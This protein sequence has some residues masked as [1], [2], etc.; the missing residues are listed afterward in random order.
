MGEMA[1]RAYYRQYGMKTS[2]VRIFTAYGP[3]EK[4]THAI[5]ALIAKAF[6][7]M[8]TYDLRGTGEHS[9][10][11]TYVQDIVDALLVASERIE[12][13]M[14]V[15]AGRDDQITLREA[16]QLVF[17]IMGWEPERIE[18]DLT[19]PQGVSSR[20]ADLTHAK[21][22]LRWEPRVS[23]EEGFRRTIDWYVATKTREGA[24]ADLEKNPIQ[25]SL[26]HR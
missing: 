8:D 23:Y 19:K 4:E 9:R 13:G 18:Y 16:A 14:A 3:R 22:L 15:N 10:G 12:N 25:T 6:I 21:G 17:D 20:A 1:L 11:L 5:I 2:S 26:V 24:A 7:R